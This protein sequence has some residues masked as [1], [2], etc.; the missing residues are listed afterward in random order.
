[1]V[2]KFTDVETHH[3]LQYVF[4]LAGL[5]ETVNLVKGI[6]GTAYAFKCDIADKDDVYRAADITR[7]EV[8][9]VR[10]LYNIFFFL[11]FNFNYIVW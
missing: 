2:H 5:E 4:V 6:G 3:S 8:G 1:M 11:F 10:N 7:K 9:D